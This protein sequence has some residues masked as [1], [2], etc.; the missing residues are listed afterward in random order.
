M[1]PLY[2]AVVIVEITCSIDCYKLQ[3]VRQMILT[4]SS[5]YSRKSVLNICRENEQL[6]NFELTARK[7]EKQLNVNI[8]R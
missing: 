7:K 6:E 1:A 8:L 3:R 2:L 4:E 5:W